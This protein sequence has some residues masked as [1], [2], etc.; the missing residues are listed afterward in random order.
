MGKTKKKACSIIE[1]AMMY[2][3]SKELYERAQKLMPA[4][5]NSPVRAFRSVGMEPPFIKR[6]QGSKL[7]DADGNEYIDYL[8]SWG[9]MILG[10]RDPT[11]VKALAEALEMGTSFGAPTALEVEMAELVIEALPSIEMV[12]MVNSGTEAA[13]SAIRLARGYTG[14]DKIIKFE[15]CYH[16]HSDGLLV[17]AGSGAATFGIPD[18]LGVPSDYA[19]ST[20]TV[21]FNDIEAVKRTIQADPEGIA[22]VILEPIAGNMGVIPPEKGFLEEIRAIT[23]KH[24][25]LLIFDEVI[26]GFRVDYG[27]VQSLYGILPDLTCLGQIIGG[28]LPVGAYGG[29]REIIEKIAPLGGVYQAGTLSG[30][31]LAMSAGIATLKRLKEPG[32]YEKLEE[33]TA[34]L[35]GEIHKSAEKAG[36][37]HTANRIGSMFCLFFT[38]EK[39]TN[40]ESAKRSD[41][42]KFTRYFSKMLGEGIYIAPSQFE[43]GFV[44]VAHTDEDIERTIEASTRALQGL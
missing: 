29:R 5:V 14:R 17:K 9:P 15:G 32:T 21:P 39:V 37:P 28:G 6:G 22:C 42:D 27:G 13:M 2:P 38:D 30:N 24:G 35:V 26:T 4:G 19:K 7:Y 16:G 23:S 44:S 43:A 11:V 3:V 18:S 31:P 33:K 20:L 41:T 1:V 36:V 25:I 8:G 34:H 10:H 12:R 40:Y